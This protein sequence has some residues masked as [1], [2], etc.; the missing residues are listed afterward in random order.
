MNNARDYHTAT[1]LT[2]GKVLVT[3]RDRGSTSLNSTELYDPPIDT[4]TT[5]HNM[6]NT[7]VEQVESVLV[8]EKVLVV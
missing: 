5:M 6:N 3:G 4:S 7:L 1:I 2:D 8:N